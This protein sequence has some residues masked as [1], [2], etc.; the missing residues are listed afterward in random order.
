MLFSTNRMDYNQINLYLEKFKKILNQTSLNKETII[1]IINNEIKFKI[2]NE[3]MKIKNDTL[4][5]SNI[6]PILKNEIFLHKE[7]IIKEIRNNGLN[8]NNIR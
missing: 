6:S 8:I 2:K 4:V 5:F 1:S 3:D 7:K